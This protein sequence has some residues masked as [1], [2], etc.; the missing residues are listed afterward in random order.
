MNSRAQ[1]KEEFEHRIIRAHKTGLSKNCT[2]GQ[3]KDQLLFIGLNV[4]EKQILPAET[5]RP[6]KYE[7]ARG[8]KIIQFPR[9]TA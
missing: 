6:Y 4:Y 9:G 1:R 8:A 5:L 2:L 3:F 7:E